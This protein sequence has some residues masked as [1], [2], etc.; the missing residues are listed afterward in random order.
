MSK[1]SIIISFFAILLIFSSCKK[2]I[3][4]KYTGNYYFKTDLFTFLGSSTHDTILFFNG[5]I[6]ENSKSTIEIEYL[7]NYILQLTIDSEGNLSYPNWQSPALYTNFQGVFHDNGD[8]DIY[9][10]EHYHGNGYNKT[11]YGT[12]LQ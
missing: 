4:K 5:T 3:A 8:V 9:M 10:Q 2:D 11:I 12:K 6:K 1:I 7:S